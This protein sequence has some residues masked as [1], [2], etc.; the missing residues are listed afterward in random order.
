[1]VLI[2]SSVW[3]ANMRQ[4]GLLERFVAFE[5]TVTCPPV[6]HEI[7][8]GSST[9]RSYLR[10][11]TMLLSIPIVESPTSLDAFLH[12]A[13]IYRIARAA[14]F[15]IRSSIDCLIAA[16]AIRHDLPLLHADRDF[17]IISR[18]TLLQAKNV[19]A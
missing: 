17:D 4:P 3:I 10:A 5:R 9:I 11:K 7:L 19:L 15:T 14:G 8:K 13:E 2:D 18:F 16:C 1:V 12:A 6:V